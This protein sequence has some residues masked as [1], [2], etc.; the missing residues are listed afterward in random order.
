[1]VKLPIKANFPNVYT[2]NPTCEYAIANGTESWQPNR[3]LQKMEFDLSVLQIHFARENDI[4]V[5]DNIPTVQFTEQLS[6]LN[7]EI[8]EFVKKAEIKSPKF[9]QRPKNKLLP[10]GWSPAM[11]KFMAALKPSCS[12]EFQQSQVCTWQ[13]EYRNLYA[14]KFALEILKKLVAEIRADYLMPESAIARICRTKKEIE[15]AHEEWGKLM[16]KSPW[17][18]SGRGLQPI[19]TKP[20]HPKVWEKLMAG[21]NEQGYLLA[22]PLLTKIL[23]FAFEFKLKKGKAEFL[24]LSFF[25]TDKKGQYQGNFLNGLPESVP[26][27]VKQFTE[28]SARQLLNPLKNEIENSDLARFYEGILGVDTLVYADDKNNLKINPCLEIN[29]RYNMGWLSIQLEK[30]LHAGK[31]GIFR[32]YYEPGKS[33]DAFKKEMEKQYPL[34]ISGHKIDNG[35]MALVDSDATTQFGA[36]LLV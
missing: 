24:G 11:H 31:K 3:L 28:K 7:I 5:T 25:S 15:I 1:M 30:L 23:D 17:S 16:V 8:P 36:Y 35:F 22:E 4:I 2:F 32:T 18:S 14:R 33:F 19:T 13:P 27:Q 20:V 26:P 29:L 34:K 9:I 6:K 21:I 12:A 10:W